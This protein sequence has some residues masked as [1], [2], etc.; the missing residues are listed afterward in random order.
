M[1]CRVSPAYGDRVARSG[2][3]SEACAWEWMTMASAGGHRGS[4]E[5]SKGHPGCR[6]RAQVVAGGSRFKCPH[7]TID[8][9]QAT[10]RPVSSWVGDHQRIPAV[11][12]FCFC[13][14]QARICDLSQ[15]VHFGSC[16]GV[17]AQDSLVGGVISPCPLNLNQK[18]R[19]SCNTRFKFL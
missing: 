8:R 9:T 4:Q 3:T 2:A 19:A 11:V 7:R 18:S 14:E 13:R 6:A 17:E 5:P 1:V 12:C 15:P 16:S 10:R